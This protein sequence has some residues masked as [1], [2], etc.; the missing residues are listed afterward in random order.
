MATRA[1]PALRRVVKP[2]GGTS[3]SS[4]LFGG[5]VPGATAATT[6]QTAR[7][8]KKAFRQAVK[9]QKKT[10]RQGAK[11]QKRAAHAFAKGARK[12]ARQDVRSQ[13]KAARTKRKETK[14]TAAG[15]IGGLF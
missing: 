11:Q 7:G 13:K 15:A 4:G 5:L 14:R 12:T 9:T 10:V 6:G 8:A 1:A 2:V 3:R